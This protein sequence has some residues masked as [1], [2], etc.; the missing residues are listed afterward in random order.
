[1]SMIKNFYQGWL[2]Y[3]LPIRIKTF[4]R[5]WKLTITPIGVTGK[6]KA[7][8]EH[9]IIAGLSSIE[10]AMLLAKNKVDRLEGVQE[11]DAN[12]TNGALL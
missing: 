3:L 12:Y 10:R 4:Y 8:G 2:R 9:F 7:S 5:G 11:W 6:H 1:M